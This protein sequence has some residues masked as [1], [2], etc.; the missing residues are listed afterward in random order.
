MTIKEL[1]QELGNIDLY[2]LDAILKDYVPKE[3]KLLDAGCGEG[4]NLVYLLKN[5][6]QCYGADTNA[7]ALR[8]LRFQLNSLAPGYPAERF[9]QADLKSLPYEDSTFHTVL[10]IAVLHFSENEEDF[11]RM[12]GELVRVL[13][14]GGKMLIRMTDSTDMKDAVAVGNGKYQL[15]D[16]SVRFLLTARLKNEMMAEH[17]L[18]YAEPYKTVVVEGMRTMN[19]W[20]VT[21]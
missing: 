9:A 6:Y 16:G 15:P 18:R 20:L 13:Q 19:T 3:G 4:R 12:F 17:S 5:G 11:R 7:D 21:K 14:P 10:C 1:N 8:M 2:V